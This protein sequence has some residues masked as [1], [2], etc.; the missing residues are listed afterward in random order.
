MG[1]SKGRQHGYQWIN[2]VPLN[3]TK[4]DDLVNFFQYRIVS[5]NGKIN[6]K[7]SWGTDI[8]VDENNV[9]TLVKG[10]RARWKIENETFNTLKNQGYPIEHNFGHGQHNLSRIFFL[11]Y[12]QAQSSSTTHVSLISLKKLHLSLLHTFHRELI[13]KYTHF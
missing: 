2:Q 8:H 10:R 4:D 7:N 9:I 5:K 3:G 6:Y 13:D 12:P 1:I 11:L